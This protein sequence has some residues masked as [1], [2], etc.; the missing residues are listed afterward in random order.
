MAAVLLCAACEGEPAPDEQIGG[1]FGQVTPTQVEIELML[2]F[3]NDTHT[4]FD[5]LDDD[6]GLDRRAAENII[7]HR[8]GAD[9]NYPSSDDDPFDSLP[10][11]DA[12][13][14]VGQTAL[15]KIYTYATTHAGSG[16]VTVEGVTFTAE[17]AAAVVWG[18]N[19]ATAVE[20]D[21]DVGLDSRA[22]D[23]LVNEA[24][25]NS[26]EEM[27]PVA[28]VG[29]SALTKLRTYAPVWQAAMNSQPGNLAGTYDGVEFDE[30]T[31]QTALEIANLATA[32]QLAA[33]GITTTPRNIIINNRPWA[34]LAAIADFS[35]I[36]PATMQALKTM[37]PS[38]T[39]PVVTP[40]ALTIQQLV[41]EAT[42]NGVGSPYYDQPVAV[43]RA[44]ITSELQTYSGGH[45]AFWV[46]DPTAGNQAQ[47]KVYVTADAAQDLS[48][49]SLFDDVTVT[50]TFTLYGST[51]EVLVDDAQLH[52]V[53]LNKSGLAYGDYYDLLDAWSSTTANPEGAVLVESSFSYTFM[54]PLPLFKDHPMYQGLPDP[55]DPDAVY[56]GNDHP[57]QL[58]CGD[59]QSV[60]DSWL[61]GQ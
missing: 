2:D 5:L 60:L 37:V 20:L 42:D 52:Q 50:G 55:Q 46:A 22:A 19:Q 21:D 48:F 12:I 17:Q 39:G 53:V 32:E 51:W 3:V 44:I 1:V 35:G 34:S 49:V 14:Y 28:Y 13:P 10:E 57:G 58:W 47:I 54:V 33:G 26:V 61:A 11:L 59:Q 27:S 30:A 43:S 15:T 8:D 56:G 24:P 29:A 16:S 40:T 31:A 25:F 23:N 45:S 4:D 9:G 6:V 36:G 41:D 38:W 18:V 7:T